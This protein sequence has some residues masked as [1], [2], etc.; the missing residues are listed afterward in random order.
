MRKRNSNKTYHYSDD[1]KAALKR[2]LSSKSSSRKSYGK[3]SS[4]KKSYDKNT[5]SRKVTRAKNRKKSNTALEKEKV[6][7]TGEFTAHPRGF[8]FVT[9][10][11]FEEDFYV[12]E[13]HVNGAMH[14]DTVQIELLPETEGKRREADIVKIISHNVEK[15]VG[16]FTKMNGFGFVIPDDKKFTD[17]LYIPSDAF[18]G[19]KNNDKVVCIYTKYSDGIKKPEGR[20]V[21][22]IGGKDDPGADILSVV[23]GMDIPTEFPT[24]V[25]AEADYVNKPVKKK[26]IKHRLDLRE[27]PMVTIDGDE[28]KDFDDA[29]SIG[30]KGKNY[31]LGVHIADVAEYVCENG[32]LDAEALKR[33][34]SVY[35]CDRVIPMLP[36]ALSN[37]ICSLN[38]GEDRLA[39]SCIMKVSPEGKVLDYK[40]DESV[41]NVDYRMTYHDVTEIIDGNEEL[42]EKYRDM[43]P[44]FLVMHE[45]SKVI[46]KKREA[47]GCIDFDFPEAEITLNPD[48]STKEIKCRERDKASLMIEDFMILANETVA[49]AFAEKELPFL[50]R[51]HGNPDMGR[52]TALNDYTETIGVTIRPKGTEVTPKEIQEV[53]KK[54]EGRPEEKIISHMV[55]RS[56]QK[57]K[58]DTDC[59]GHFGLAATYYS[60]FTSPI[61]RY[62]DLQ[63]HRIIKE[64]LHDDLN[65]KRRKHY[66]K[67]LPEVAERTSVLER[68][69]DEA[70]RET[71]KMKEAEYMK[72]HIGDEFVGTISGVTS[73]GIYVELP[74]TIEG[75]IHISNIK[76]DY[77]NF[78][79]TR[80]EL[81]GE[82]TH[83]VYKI[84]QK[85]R[86]VVDNAN[87]ETRTIDFLLSENQYA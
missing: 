18:L 57:A 16:T 68:R 37:G 85:V 54:I 72:R 3:N 69:A 63:I 60:H 22:I 77:F 78:D 42:S 13:L 45:L 8:G 1:R 10:E 55:L 19:A 31:I 6:L 26:H 84:G 14:K 67:I 62:P 81:V 40:I 52:V 9:C 82:K 56:M 50:Y 47:D 36:K 64:Y 25:L 2:K 34:T 43:V 86:V 38:Q 53:L 83:L 59:D 41:I 73:F 12:P 49:R 27:I 74:N 65:K 80:M 4:S 35:L 75:L 58:Y 76:G 11:G 32:A 70:E 29:V 46:R 44:H 39:L 30:I 33:G 28:T 87:K 48:G 51:V 17:D 21:E 24:E 66:N 23:M 20:I 71:D 7:L 5:S 15:I 61:R 79:E